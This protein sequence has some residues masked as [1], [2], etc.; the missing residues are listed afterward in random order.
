[1]RLVTV[2]FGKT[3]RFDAVTIWPWIFMRDKSLVPGY[4]GLLA[5][6]LVHYK[7]QRA[8]WVLPW[9]VLYL[10]SRRFRYREEILGHAAQVAHADGCMTMAQGVYSIRHNYKLKI[11]LA[12]IMVDLS[13]AVE[14]QYVQQ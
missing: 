7:R 6:E 8:I 3:W 14:K 1:M 12:Q 13:L 10:T 4:R 5:H 2:D 11:G 9:W